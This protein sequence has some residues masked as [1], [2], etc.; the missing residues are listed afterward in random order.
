MRIAEIFIIAALATSGLLYAQPPQDEG[1]IGT[2]DGLSQGMV[3]TILQ[4]S[5]GFLWIGTKDGLNRFDG[6]RLRVYNSSP[7]DS[8]SLAGH[9]VNTLHEDAHH[10]IW[11]GTENNGIS[12]FSPYTG[13]FHHISSP[14]AGLPS[15]EIISF[16]QQNDSTYWAGT[17]MGLCRLTA[18]FTSVSRMA[19][20]SL[21]GHVRARSVDLG[22]QAPPVINALAFLA[23]GS[24]LAASTA[25]LYRIDPQTLQPEIVTPALG[26]HAINPPNQYRTLLPLP[27][28][29]VLVPT[30]DEIIHLDSQLDVK[31]VYVVPEEIRSLYTPSLIR[32]P[33]GEVW[34]ASGGLFRLRL[35]SGEI[36][37]VAPSK[38]NYLTPQIYMDRSGI[39]WLGTN[40]YGVLP[41]SPT[42]GRFNHHLEGQTIR[43]IYEDLEGQVWYWSPQKMLRYSPASRNAA[44][45]DGFPDWLRRA[46]W[47]LNPAPDEYWLHYPIEE[48]GACLAFVNPKTGTVKRFPYEGTP[49][50]R[51]P[52]VCSSEGRLWLGNRDGQLMSLSTRQPDAGIQYYDLSE[53]FPEINNIVGI[54]AIFFDEHHQQLWLGTQY[55][56]IGFSAVAG[57]LSRPRLYQF[58]A[59]TPNSLSENFIHS[60]LIAP[61]APETLWVGTK[62]G[63]L[64]ALDIPSGEFR[65]YTVL[66]GLPNDVIYGILAGANDDLW[67]STNRGLSN[68]QPQTGG[69]RNYTAQDGLQDNEFNTTSYFRATDGTLYFGG[70]NGINFFHPSELKDSSARPQIQFTGLSIN[71][72]PYHV[73]RQDALPAWIPTAS[74]FTLRHSDNVLSFQFAAL[75]FTAAANNRYRYQLEGVDASLVE[76]GNRNEVTYANLSPGDY[77][78]KVWGANSQGV[79]STKP[80]ALSFSITPPWWAS[81]WAWAAYCLLAAAAIWTA[82]SVQVRRAKLR[83]Q[84]RFEQREAERLSE[85]DRIKSNFFSSITHEFRTPLTLILEPARQLEAR[86]KQPQ[87]RTWARLIVRNAEKMLKLVNQLLDINRMDG[88]LMPVLY[89][90]GDLS[91]FMAD[92]VQGFSSRAKGQELSL[93]FQPG[94]DPALQ[95]VYFDHDKVEK[96]LTNLISNALKFTPPGGQVVVSSHFMPGQPLP[97]Q[98]RVTDN[99]LGI[100]K[101]EQER[102]FERFYRSDSHGGSQ[103]PGT[104]IGL[105]LCK[106]LSTLMNGHIGVESLPGGGS[107]FTV[108]LPIPVSQNSQDSPLS[109][110]ENAAPPVGSSNGEQLS[111]LIVDDN[112]EV[113]AFLHSILQPDFQVFAA[114]EGLTGLQLATEHTPDLIISDVMMPRMDGFEFV[115]LLRKDKR[116]SH[117]PVVMLTAKSGLDSRIEGLNH[118]AEAYIGKPFHV[119]ELIAQVNALLRQ[120]EYMQAYFQLSGEPANTQPH[121]YQPPEAEA[122]FILSLKQA[123]ETHIDNEQLTIELLAAEVFMSRSQLHRKLKALT[124]KSATAYLRD[125]RLERAHQ[126]LQQGQF[127]VAEVSARTGF[128]SPQYFATRYKEK[129]GYSPSET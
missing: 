20:A 103:A 61:F 54:Q 84:L 26:P 70:I 65:S 36:A 49:E 78:F 97:L 80:A 120:R 108:S 33:K 129:F 13:K 76:A 40:G 21:S 64:N 23:D 8:F 2:K 55:G 67:L 24:L 31:Q 110:P 3:H 45:P 37:S 5:K 22:G 119:E 115:Q 96:I 77:T 30:P 99:G 41:Y 98:F 11:V 63:G 112:E 59:N 82:Y 68:F 52:M 66:D 106:E 123:I 111:I 116:T 127:N 74:R 57:K 32:S 121:S 114:H 94:A 92:I 9:V 79:W 46:T 39:I 124:G 10:N 122:E 101:E 87:Q 100:P 83:N 93:L 1:L 91:L 56:L 34:G 85:L 38:G 48:K 18:S 43:Q 128:G 72:Q 86:Q 75:D 95:Y 44:F 17:R 104:G 12:I 118:G 15:N 14:A 53:W 125:F 69:F 81:H 28:G 27:D 126:L 35:G 107:Q 89:E 105:A 58:D 113:R 71:N 19:T 50:P 102:I 29:G 25:Q 16:V 109:L 47:L 6:Y 60:L 4:D 88:Q 117:I 7:E 90:K 73:H 51:S 42:A 62:G